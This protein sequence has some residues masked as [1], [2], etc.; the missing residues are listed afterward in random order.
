MNWGEATS[1]WRRVTLGEIV[2]FTQKPRKLKYSDA[3][4]I[5]FVPMELIPIGI[6]DFDS[7]ILRT[8]GEISS[9]TYFEPGDI[10]LAKI[11]P[12]FENGKQGI[13]RELPTP[14]GIATTEVIPF[15]EVKGVTD[16]EFLFFNLLRTQVRTELAGKMEGSTG[17]QR[18]NKSSLE[19]LEITLPPLPEQRAIARALRAVQAAR[20]TRQREVELERERKT[21]LMQHLFTKGTRGE[22]T[23][24]TEFGEVPESW[25]V[26]PLKRIATLRRGFDLPEYSRQEGKV[27]VIGSNGVV[28]WHSKSVSGLPVPG[29]MTGRS[30]SIGSLMYSETPY[31]P[32]N[33][34]LYVD[35]FKGN[36]SLFVYYWLHFVEFERY[37]EGVSVPTLN[38][39]MLH[40]I[41]LPLPDVE[42]QVEVAY[43]CRSID[44]KITALDREAALLDELFRALLE[45]LMT[46]QLSAG[47]LI[48]A[49]EAP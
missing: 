36:D 23:K 7:Y 22:L 9:G 43:I 27:P 46:G 1:H 4:S 30:G 5:P 13:I 12:S 25:Q 10:L 17:R 32:L 44:D 41:L 24:M 42:E 49:E 11:T 8:P 28:G 18:L 48:E 35:S 15:R 38:R 29:V 6:I 2:T 47:P 21:I 34:S 19:S 26:V 39:N 37:A 14:Y 3:E 33:T 40:S 45:D 20:E 16:K 31:W